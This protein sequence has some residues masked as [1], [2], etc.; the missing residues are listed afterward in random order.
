MTRVRC[1]IEDCMF[2]KKGICQAKEIEIDP[3][4]GCLTF[5]LG[6]EEEEELFSDWEEERFDE[7]EEW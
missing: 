7:E 1:Y 6:E 4:E 2:W 5:R 3:D